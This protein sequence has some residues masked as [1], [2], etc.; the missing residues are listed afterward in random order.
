MIT[1]SNVSKKYVKNG[2]SKTIFSNFSF[3]FEKGKNYALMGLNGSGKSTLLR[4]IS[5]SELPDIGFVKRTCKVSWP[6]G[7]SGGL[8]GQLTG[9]QNIKFVS[10]QGSIR[11]N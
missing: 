4:M 11:N 2:I 8:N 1:L 3:E 6:I 5:G 9:I 10:R 7:F